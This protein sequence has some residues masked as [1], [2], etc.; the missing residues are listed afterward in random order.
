MTDFSSYQPPG[1]YVE[2]IIPPLV[3]TVGIQPSVI[4]IVGPAVGYREHTDTVVL[5]GTAASDLTQHGI[6]PTTGFVVV[7]ASGTV[8][9]TDDYTLVVGGGADANVGTTQ[10]NT[11]TI[12]RSGGSTIPDGATVYISYRYTDETFF[13]PFLAKDYDDVRDA[14]GE[15]FNETTG[16]IISP[17]SL[18]AKIAF[19]NGAVQ[20]I[21]VPTTGAADTVTRGQLT[22]AY[23]KLSAFYSVNIVVPL[24]VGL[25]GSTGTEGD[26]LNVGND[27]KA[28][29][30]D[31]LREGNARIGII[32]YE[33]SVTVLPVAMA[34]EF[35]SSRVMLAWPNRM[36]YYNG[37]TNTTIEVGGYYLAAA[38]AGRFA[39]QNPQM[40]LTKKQIRGFAGI[41]P[42]VLQTMTTALRN[43]WSDGGV[44]VTEL[45]QDGRLVVR[46]GTST[47]RTNVHTRE[48]SLTRA[49]DALVRVVKT[50]TEGNSLIGT[51]I[52]PDTPGRVKGIVA[53]ALETARVAGLILGW[54]NLK[55]RQRSLE[56]A[57]IEV[58]FEYKPAY[59]LNYI[60]ISF[61]INTTTGETQPI[62][63]AAP[64]TP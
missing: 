15:P 5:T 40:P 26:I 22:D 60:V 9:D 14:Y 64:V 11:L 54:L 36:S 1:V 3:S 8:Y 42:A 19:E 13:N 21:C 48:V 23:D 59:P 2:E 56:P 31:Q 52:E 51:P 46:H 35:A 18:A 62:D 10:D 29:V 7:D 63:L 33:T 39:A 4:A 20:I 6:N 50:T 41:A 58:K 27:L 38:Y 57:I 49:K 47:D 43:T 37:Y 24:T 30:D 45:S 61:A 16:A 32:G 44:A 25:T 28:H 55:V 34:T 17:L 53:G 12:A